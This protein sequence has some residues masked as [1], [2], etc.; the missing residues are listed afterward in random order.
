MCTNQRK[1]RNK[2]TGQELYVKCGHCPACLQEKA[3]YRVSRIGAQESADMEMIMIG[4]TYARHCAP[5]VLRS[6]VELFS[7]GALLTLPVYR[8]THF[9]KVRKTASY[10]IGYRT[11]KEIRKICEVDYVCDTDLSNLRDLRFERGKIGVTYY[12][13]VQRFIARLRLNLKRHYNYEYPIKTYCCSE[14]GAGKQEGKGIFRPHFH[15]LLSCRK[16][17]F[18]T[19]R[20]AII[21]SWPF[22][23]LQHFPR[24]VE[25]AYKAKSYV[26]SYVNCGSDFPSFLKTYFK[27]KHSYSKG[28]GC[29]SNLFKLPSILQ[30]FERGHLTYTSLR[31]DKAN[32][33]VELPYPKYIIHRYFPLFKGYNR[34]N[35]A[36]LCDVMER[37]FRYNEGEDSRSHMTPLYEEVPKTDHLFLNE[38]TFPVILDL[39]DVHKIKVRLRNAL[40]RF[41]ECSGLTD[42]SFHDY[43]HLH[44]RIW[45]LYHSDVL[46]LHLQ[47]PDIPLQEKYDNLYD[48][49]SSFEDGG[50]LP[51][52]FTPDMLSVINPND[53]SSVVR[54]TDRFTTSY[55]DHMK[56]RSVSGTVLSSL[57]EEF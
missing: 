55:Y 56:K 30:K 40:T 17:D 6:D 13:D 31:A 38:M 4:L 53:Y 11:T 7:K 49:K 57:Y 15:I 52:G 44:K 9:R 12:P 41:R 20:S 2:Y 39:N 32:A 42:Y 18:K 1:I 3:A 28:Y 45:S 46:R 43:F 54:N 50:S 35:P 22:S 29:N 25:L 5:Y 47:N 33:V 51:V 23:N 16:G 26:A 19:L 24:A 48:L 21:A 14:Y 37:L 34:I 8:D 27:P 10:D 36:S